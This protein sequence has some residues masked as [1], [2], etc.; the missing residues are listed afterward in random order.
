MR[1]VN[2]HY[3]HCKQASYKKLMSGLSL[4]EILVTVVVLSV[5]LL[6][7]AGMQA[8]GM[9]YSHDSYARSQATMLANE[10]IERM[11]ANPDGV[12]NGD[13]KTA[14]DALDCSSVNNDPAHPMNAAPSCSGSTA[15]EFCSVTQLATLDTFRIGCGQFLAT[16]NAL[17]GGVANLLPGGAIAID[18]TDSNGGTPPACLDDNSRTVRITWQDPDQKGTAATLQVEVNARIL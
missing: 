3:K 4:I 7:I 16:P 14:V 10:L 2:T 9:R 8:F 5:G 18:C 6:G 11:H 15:S 12:S 13:Y 1:E 17:I